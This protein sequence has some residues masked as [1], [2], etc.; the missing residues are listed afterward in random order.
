MED[1]CRAIDEFMNATSFKSVPLVISSKDK[2]L[3]K[4]YDDYSSRAEKLD[5][6]MIGN[7]GMT[8]LQFDMFVHV[9]IATMFF[10]C[11]TFFKLLGILQTRSQ[12]HLDSEVSSDCK[13][14]Q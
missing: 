2:K 9:N 7:N 1:A 8:I 11:F 10:V 6:L 4:L 5:R 3:D 12:Q 13:R 14:H